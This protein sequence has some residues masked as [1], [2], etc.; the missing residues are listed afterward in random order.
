MELY[1][2]SGET[3]EFT[4]IRKSHHAKDFSDKLS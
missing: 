1:H 2:A 3:V 4:E